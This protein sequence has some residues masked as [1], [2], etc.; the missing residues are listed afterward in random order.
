MRNPGFIPVILFILIITGCTSGSYLVRGKEYLEINKYDRAIKELEQA[1]DEKGDLYYYI[2]TYSSLGDAY[3][4]NGQANQAMAVYRNALQM[5]QMR[6]RE[7]SSQRMDIRRELNSRSKPKAPARQDEDMRLADE[8]WKL[9][10]S[11]DDIK[12]RLEDLL[13]KQ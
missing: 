9:K 4:K 6:L 13:D 12:N 2:D 11:A 8:E 3:A 5:I 7:I 1:A 10:R